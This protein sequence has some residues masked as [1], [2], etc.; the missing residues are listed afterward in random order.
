MK[1]NLKHYRQMRGMTQQELSNLSNISRPYISAL[2]NYR[3]YKSPTLE[4]LMSLS[5]ALQVCPILLLNYNCNNCDIIK[6]KNKLDCKCFL[7]K[8]LQSIVEYLE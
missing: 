2:E 3:N 6:N 1:L 8:E 7:K 4:T 5:R